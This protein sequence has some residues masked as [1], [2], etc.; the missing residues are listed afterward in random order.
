M[1]TTNIIDDFLKKSITQPIFL[2]S[3]IQRACITRTL[4]GPI[5]SD[6]TM[7]YSK[8]APPVCK[9]VCFVFG[10]PI[11]QQVS[12]V[13]CAACARQRTHATACHSFAVGSVREPGSLRHPQVM[14]VEGINS[15]TGSPGVNLLLVQAKK[16]THLRVRAYL[17]GF[18][19]NSVP[20]NLQW[21][22]SIERELSAMEPQKI[23][24]RQ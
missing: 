16:R 11:P 5:D 14:P 21:V 15:S 19:G 22:K 3:A 23:R 18:S 2:V 17:V 13:L 8:Q 1:H 20:S 6:G 4:P 10:E 12:P 24:L 9:G 7:R